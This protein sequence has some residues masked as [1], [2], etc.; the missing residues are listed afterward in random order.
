M[1]RYLT[2]RWLGGRYNDF[3]YS[4]HDPLPT[5][6]AWHFS[7]PILQGLER[8][9]GEIAERIA[10]ANSAKTEKE[11]VWSPASSFPFAFNRVI[12]S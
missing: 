6:I 10:V 4:N 9:E 12:I 8:C 7:F 1:A 2:A 3:A 5:Q 11:L